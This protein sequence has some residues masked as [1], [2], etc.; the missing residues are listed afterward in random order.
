MPGASDAAPPG[1]CPPPAQQHQE[2]VVEEVEVGESLEERRE[3][4]TALALGWMEEPLAPEALAW[5]PTARHKLG[6]RTCLAGG[7]SSPLPG[8]PTLAGT[9]CPLSS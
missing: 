9:C 7:P 6:S 2:L 8:L 3:R 1:K 4:N 5:A